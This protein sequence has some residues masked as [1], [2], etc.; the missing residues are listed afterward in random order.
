M[1]LP[2]SI[3]P[4]LGGTWSE[5]IKTGIEVSMEEFIFFTAMHIELGNGSS[6]HFWT[7]HWVG[8]APLKFLF[9][10]FMNCQ[11]R[12]MNQYSTWDGTMGFPGD[13]FWGGNTTLILNNS[14]PSEI[15]K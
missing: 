7:D 2:S 10:I 15:F 11:S 12:R 9:R 6:T 8:D 4:K 3:V 13:G 1:L 5:I 14:K